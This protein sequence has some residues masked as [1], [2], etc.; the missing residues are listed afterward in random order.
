MKCIQ[1]KYKYD[2]VM[3]NRIFLVLTAPD[4]ITAIFAVPFVIAFAYAVYTFLPVG[5][6]E[7]I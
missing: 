4:F 2:R 5:T 7:L 3:Y 6:T 1:Y